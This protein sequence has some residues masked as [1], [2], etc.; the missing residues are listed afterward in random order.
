[1]HCDRNSGALKAHPFFAV[2]LSKQAH[3][4]YDAYHDCFEA[5]HGVTTPSWFKGNG[6][7]GVSPGGGCTNE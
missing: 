3:L 4:E 5:R 1:M 7:F 2:G 6:A